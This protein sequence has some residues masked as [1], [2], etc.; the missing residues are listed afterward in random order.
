MGPAQDPKML[1]LSVETEN[2]QKWQNGAPLAGGQNNGN[3]DE[4][5]IKYKAQARE[6][7]QPLE[8]TPR[9]VSVVQGRNVM[10]GSVRGAATVTKHA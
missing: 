9:A 7:R 10:Y 5:K 4:V 8:R 3:S 6:G 2:E 1:L